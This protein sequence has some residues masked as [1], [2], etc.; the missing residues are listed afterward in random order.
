MTAQSKKKSSKPAFSPTKRARTSLRVRALKTWQRV[1]VRTPKSPHHAFRLTRP[2]IYVGTDDLKAAWRLQLDSWRFIKRYK[3]I[4]LGL[5]LLYALVAYF[6]VGGVSQLDYVGFKNATV[7]VVDGD[8]GAVGKA[9]SLFGAA[10]TGNLSSPPSD[11]QQ[12]M[13]AVLLML[14]WLAIVWAA[15]MLAA[16]KEVRV[17][18][19]LYNSGGPIIP[20]L[21]VLAVIALQLIPGALGIFAYATALNGGLLDGG[22]ESMSFAVA[23]ILLCLLSLYFMVSSLTAL[24]V[25]TLPGTY[26]WQALRTARE[27]VMNRRWGIVLRVLALAVHVVLI[28]GVVLIPVFLLDNWLRF[29]WLPLVPIAVQALAGITLVYTSV[30]VYRLYRSLL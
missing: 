4:L 11:V 22:V 18:D 13:S 5:G 17:R 7:Q 19:A 24:I 29:D 6:L 2:R 10:L 27:L 20:M 9:F 16:D 15:R 12:F 28:W 14:F 3:R 26:P 8:V 21:V 23:A 1:V 30:Y 25:I